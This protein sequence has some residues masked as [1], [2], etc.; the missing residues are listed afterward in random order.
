MQ[1]NVQKTAPAL[2]A[3]VALSGKISKLQLQPQHQNLRN[4][5]HNLEITY[6][7]GPH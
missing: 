5:N 1:W 2:I 4:Q 3:P 7:I 6:L